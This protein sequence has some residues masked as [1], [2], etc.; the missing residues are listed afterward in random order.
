MNDRLVLLVR[1]KVFTVPMHSSGK[2]GDT[3]AMVT[4][5]NVRWTRWGGAR[6]TAP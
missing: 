3:S 6:A 1:P 2:S 5:R 4:F